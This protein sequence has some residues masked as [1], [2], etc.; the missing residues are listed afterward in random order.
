VYLHRSVE[1]EYKEHRQIRTILKGKEMNLPKPYFVSNGD[2]ENKHEAKIKWWVNPKEALYGEY[3]FNCPET[4]KDNP[5]TAG[6]IPGDEFYKSDTPVFFGH[7]ILSTP[8]RLQSP[9]VACL[10][11]GVAKNGLLVAYRFNGE[12]ELQMKNFV[13]VLKEMEE[14]V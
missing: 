11:Y 3:L 1:K 2:G 5:I 6:N 13:S 8:V 9:K 4:L 14:A 7:Y 12:K 10:D